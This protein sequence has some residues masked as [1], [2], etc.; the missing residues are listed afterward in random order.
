MVLI[1]EAKRS[2]WW[3]GGLAHPPSPQSSFLPPPRPCGLSSVLTEPPC[4]GLWLPVLNLI[5]IYPVRYFP[6][7]THTSSVLPLPSHPLFKEGWQGREQWEWI[8]VGCDLYTT[9]QPIPQLVL[10]PQVR[11]DGTNWQNRIHS[12][13]GWRSNSQLL[14]EVR[15]LN[16]F[17]C[18]W[19]E[20]LVV[21]KN[22]M[23]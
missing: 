6:A 9:W 15:G 20:F 22:P 1:T 21:L 2:C 7:H 8:G 19:M 14:F 18:L 3:A 17:S 4:I 16:V 12:P 5:Q 13:L 23:A 11:A 10:A